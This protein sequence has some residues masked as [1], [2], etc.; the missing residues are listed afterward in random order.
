MTHH[1]FWDAQPVQT[2]TGSQAP[3]ILVSDINTQ[4][5]R[6]FPK[7]CPELPEGLDWTPL[8]LKDIDEIA[9]FLETNYKLSYSKAL[10]KV[11]FRSSS[12]TLMLGMTSPN[13][14]AGF[15]AALGRVLK[16][17]GLTHP[18]IEINFLCIR[19]DL[20]NKGLAPKMITEITRRIRLTGSY[21][22]AYY[23]SPAPLPHPYVTHRI[24]HRLLNVEH[25]FDSGFFQADWGPYRDHL[26]HDAL[27][28]PQWEYLSKRVTRI[29]ATDVSGECLAEIQGLYAKHMRERAQV[30]VELDEKYLRALLD[31]C[32]ESGEDCMRMYIL[33]DEESGALKAFAVVLRVSYNFRTRVSVAQLH[34]HA[35]IDKISMT[36]LVKGML[37]ALKESFHLF[38]TTDG[39]F[40]LQ[41]CPDLGIKLATTK[42]NG[43]IYNFQQRVL[44]PDQ[45]GVLI[46]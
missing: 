14:L 15:I 31:G 29:K 12:E 1:A 16:M 33:R 18:M 46:F 37:P 43:Y 36:D 44:S 5:T 32:I 11:A 24:F 17:D 22:G 3:Q 28:P 39:P 8:T 40:R 23:T 21:L 2:D 34:L 27:V 42:L 25:L 38:N 13:G 6:V 35:A 20:R 9:A 30:Y 26:Q 19:E 45:D 4:D 41:D 10:L 7:R